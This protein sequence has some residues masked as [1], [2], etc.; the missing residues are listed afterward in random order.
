MGRRPKPRDQHERDGTFR[1]DRH[2]GFRSPD[3]PK[4][5]PV[6]P[7]QLNAEAQAEWDRMIARLTSSGALS[8][9]DDGALYLHCQLFAET[10]GIHVAQRETA[11]SI[12]TL[13]ENFDK[14]KPEDVTT[15]QRIEF[16]GVMARMRKLEAS[17]NTKVRQGRM[18]LRIMLAEFGL[19]PAARGRVKLLEQKEPGAD[20]FTA[21]QR[22]KPVDV[23]RPFRGAR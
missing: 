14:L 2:A 19:T 8:I 9:V 13:Q 12:R 23:V 1:R 3:A 10:E 15:A 16:A 22:A 5:I 7:K 17:Y 21:F 4:G 11:K 20:A 6:P 18:A